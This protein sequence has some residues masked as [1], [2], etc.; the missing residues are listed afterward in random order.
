[1]TTK[2]PFGGFPF[3]RNGLSTTDKIR[4]PEA[5]DHR[6]YVLEA[7]VHSAPAEFALTGRFPISGTRQGEV[8]VFT[9]KIGSRSSGRNRNLVP[10]TPPAY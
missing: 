7:A 1:M 3:D 10:H 5:G 8:L 6:R 4:T 2:R 9:S